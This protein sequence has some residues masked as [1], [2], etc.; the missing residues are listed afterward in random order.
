MNEESLNL[1]IK[2]DIDLVKLSLD[3]PELFLHIINRYKNPLSSY[4]RR[5]TKVDEDELEDILQEVFLKTY[6]N[7][8][9]FKA[10]L[11]F[12]SW[13]YRITHNQVI[14]RYRRSKARPEGNYIVL[15]DVFLDKL[16]SEEN[17]VSDI[18]FKLKKDKILQALNNLDEK[19]REILILRF[20]EEKSYQEI[21]DI[22]KKPEGTV[23]S[24]INKAKKEFK[25]EID[26][27]KIDF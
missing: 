12:S 9:D 19:Y 27:Q 16:V 26:R 22:I 13:I 7:L 10:D 8:N 21:S 20:L 23:A 6:L 4:I 11:K 2:S 3:N 1:D 17:I 24:S 25:K 15:D 18:D 14:S 5:L